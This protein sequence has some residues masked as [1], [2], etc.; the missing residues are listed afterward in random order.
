MDHIVGLRC[1]LCGAEYKLDEITYVC[2][3]HGDMGNVDVLYDYARIAKRFSREALAANSDPSIWRYLPLLPIQPETVAR[4]VGHSAHPLARVGGTP[5]YAPARLREAISLPNLY[6]KDDGRNA[7]ASFKDRASAV[8]IAK[9]IELGC[10]MVCAA[11]TGNAASSLAC[12]SA[13][14]GLGNIIFVPE[15]APEAKI[16]QLLIFGATVLAVK[17]NYDAAFDLSIAASKEFGW[18]CRNTGYNPYTVEGK[19][20]VSFEICEQLSWLAPDRIFVSVGDGNII[21]GVYKGL[22]NL[23][24]LGW[25]DKMPKIM[26]VQSELSA[27]CANAW[28]AGTEIITPV[29]AT[30]IADSISVDLPRDGVRA[31]RAVRESDGAYITVS[32]EEILQAIPILGKLAGVFAEPAGSTAYAGLA[33]AMRQGLVLPDETIVVIVTGNG[34]K[35]VRSAIKVAGKPVSI[36][37]TLDEVKRVIK[38]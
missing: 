7:S 8:A 32:D 14:I 31:V 29:S 6:V 16:A 2:P 21:T 36:A 34:L 1:S 24:G 5:L 28:K 30:T 17:G 27:A 9:A 23:L 25:I 38:A 33:K 11:S 4:L 35:D 12:L 10:K 13:G 22:Q 37:P 18:Y 26:G 15:T 3:H 20:T 19:K